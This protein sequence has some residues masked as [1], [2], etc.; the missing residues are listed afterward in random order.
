MEDQ[1]Q[2][3]VPVDLKEIDFS[4][5][6]VV[7]SLVKEYHKLMFPGETNGYVD[8]RFHAVADM[9]SG[10]YDGFQ[11]MDTAYHDL[12]HT[13]QATLC[14]VHLLYNRQLNGMVSQVEHA[15]FK[16]VLVA[17]LLHDIGYLKETDDR[18]GTGA[19]YT[20]IHE[21]RSCLH[22][23]RYLIKQGWIEKDISSVERLINCTGPLSD[24]TEIPFQSDTERLL[25]QLVCTADFIGQMSDPCYVDKLTVLY[26]EFEESYRYQGLPETEWP[27]DSYE[28]LLRQTPVFWEKFVH[29]KMLTECDGVW[30]YFTHPETSQNVYLPAVQR[31]IEEIHKKIA[32]LDA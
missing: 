23:R 16:I 19:K 15:D 27:F 21:K 7:C 32:A 12:G 29:Y 4:T 11:P 8:S 24:I 20:H 18:E 1:V 2:T 14:L 9:F 30:K 10:N 25:G 3:Y 22:A 28:N 26:Q 17:I 6:D 5:S 31:N 13:L